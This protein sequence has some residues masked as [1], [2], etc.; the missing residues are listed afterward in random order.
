M[1]I[2]EALRTKL[3]IRNNLVW[4]VG[5]HTWTEEF[6]GAAF[7]NADPQFVNAAAG[8]FHLRTTSPAVAKGSGSLSPQF[9]LTGARRNPP[10]DLGAFVKR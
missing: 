5:L 6:N 8:D 1:S 4:P 7:I 9:D 3:S 10:V 2:P